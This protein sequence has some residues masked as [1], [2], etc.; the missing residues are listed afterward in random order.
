MSN[1]II[2][3]I[4]GAV[5]GIVVIIAIVLIVSR[6]QKPEVK[7]PTVLTD[8]TIKTSKDKVSG[9]ENMGNLPLIVSG[10]QIGRSNPFESY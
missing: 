10:D 3:L 5:G 6:A 9:L 4:V 7:T 2:S 8:Q 1:K